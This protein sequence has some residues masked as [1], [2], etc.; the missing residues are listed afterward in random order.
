[1]RLVFAGTPVVALPSLEALVAA[2]HEVAAVLTRAPAPQGRHRRPAPSP[3]Q[4]WAEAR[5]IEVLAP[6]SPRDP[7]LA[8]RL[9]ELAPRACPVVAYG[10]LVPA[11]LLDLPELGWINLHFSL[12]PAWRGAA[13]VQHA[14][15]NGDPSLGAT[16][17]RLVAALDA[18]PWW[19]QLDL[20]LWP[21]ATSGQAL[22]RLAGL[23]AGLLVESLAAAAAGEAPRPQAGPV[24]L[25]P[26]ITP[27][28]VR[29]DW[30][31]PA[32]R[33]DRL[34]R[35][36]CP[37][38]GAWTMVAGRRLTVLAVAPTAE[39]L[40]PGVIARRPRTVL[41]GTGTTALGLV[42]VQPEGKRAMPG[43]DWARGLRP[44]APLAADLEPA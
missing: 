11:A 40:P 27:A 5:G 41:V 4:A 10:G 28:L 29:L 16:V 12:L 1:M 31:Q 38:P 33:L 15:L 42:E 43:A 13:P 20:P 37:Q 24:S 34:V 18:G 19:R 32:E 35:A 8:R 3:V 7:E 23:G 2:G 30:R 26:K 21:N 17:F 6:A 25:A 22:E 36:A 39:S 9:A 14:I 44:D